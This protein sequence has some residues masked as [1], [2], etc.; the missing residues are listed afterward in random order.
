MCTALYPAILPIRLAVVAQSQVGWTPKSVRRH[1]PVADSP[2]VRNVGAK[3]P[4]DHQGTVGP[5]FKLSPS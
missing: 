3:V 5:R 1:N 2:D 4:V